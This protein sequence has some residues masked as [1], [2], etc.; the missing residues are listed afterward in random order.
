MNRTRYD[1][2]HELAPARA[3]DG[4]GLEVARAAF[5]RGRQEEQ[6]HG[7]LTVG[8][9]GGSLMPGPR[10]GGSAGRV[11]VLLTACLLLLGVGAVGAVLVDDAAQPADVGP[12]VESSETVE[13]P[14]PPTGPTPT[15][16]STA[17]D[18]TAVQCDDLNSSL[19]MAPE[20]PPSEWPGVLDHGWTLPDVPV[21]AAPRLHGSPMECAG[22]VAAAGFADLADSRAVVV[23]M[24]RKPMY[25]ALPIPVAS[26][27]EAEV[28]TGGSGDHYVEWADE[29]GQLW[30]AEAGGISAG[31]FQAILETLTYGPEGS[32]TGPV[33]DGFEQVEVP[34]EVE[35][36]TTLYLWQMRHDD[37]SSYLWV[38]WP[39]TTPIEA[40]LADGRGNEAVEFD[41][42]VALYNESPRGGPANPPSLKWDRNGARFWLLDAGADLE[43]LKQRARSVRPL[44]LDDP[45]LVPFMRD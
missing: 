10:R 33:P 5:E 11:L 14:D 15:P 3:V 38:R 39:V 45:R 21:T 35:P 27:H 25:R 17:D 43:T 36:G 13:Q 20:L 28:G 16:L 8:G 24:G 31:E 22:E 12:R 44:D 32:V 4:T 30:Y 7:L 29:D 37:V 23:Y 6:A 2:L 41:G 19:D 42:G 40:G 9:R 34:E 18:G 26:L 1:D